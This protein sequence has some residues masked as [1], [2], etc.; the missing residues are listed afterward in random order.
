[1]IVDEGDAKRVSNLASN[2]VLRI[3]VIKKKKLGNTFMLRSP[4]QMAN[5]IR[6]S[7]KNDQSN[8]FM[9]VSFVT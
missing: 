6:R 5:Q 4:N 1:M 2:T 3:D 9:T 7:Y 8:A